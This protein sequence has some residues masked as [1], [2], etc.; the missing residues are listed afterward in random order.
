[1]PNKQLDPIASVA[2]SIVA[3]DPQIRRRMQRLVNALLTDAEHT[4]QWGSHT[5]KASLM[6]SVM[7]ALLRSMQGADADASSAAQKAAYERVMASLRSGG[8]G[9]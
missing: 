5:E 7:P 8:S 2:A 3:D 4:I 9:A 6:R 1:M